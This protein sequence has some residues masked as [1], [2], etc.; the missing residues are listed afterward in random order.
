MRGWF[1]EPKIQRA[2]SEHALDFWD[3]NRRKGRTVSGGIQCAQPLG[4]AS[5]THLFGDFMPDARPRSPWSPDLLDLIVLPANAS[6]EAKSDIAE[7]TQRRVEAFLA[8]REVE[9]P[10]GSTTPASSLFSCGYQFDDNEIH[11][12]L[13]AEAHKWR[14]ILTP[15]KDKM[16]HEA[17]T[18]PPE[19]ISLH[20]KMGFVAMLALSRLIPADRREGLDERFFTA[21]MGLIASERQARL[22]QDWMSQELALSVKSAGGSISE[23]KPFRPKF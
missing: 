8:S 20:K 7:Q 12:S 18:H 9:L 21:Q 4:L 2:L 19:S 10:D 3:D 6:G 22:A 17:M 14:Q 5:S 15:M 13:Q 23:S 11:V 1:Q 16:R